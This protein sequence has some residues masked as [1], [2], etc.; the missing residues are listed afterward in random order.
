MVKKTCKTITT[1][2]HSSVTFFSR[3]ASRHFWPKEAKA[4]IIVV[5]V[6]FIHTF[7]K[8]APLMANKTNGCFVCIYGIYNR[9]E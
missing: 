4:P 5:A 2:F 3:L 1:N 6:P 8:K 9:L 7:C